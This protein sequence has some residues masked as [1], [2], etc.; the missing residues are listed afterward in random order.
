MAYIEVVAGLVFLVFAGDYLVRGAVSLARRAGIS[1]MIIALT[2][3]AFGTSAPELMVGVDAV[4]KG[5]PTL[6]LGNIVGSNIANVLLVVGLPAIIAPMTC[7]APRIKKNLIIM[8][9]A[10]ALFIGMAFSGTFTAIH[11][12]ALL[13]TLAIFIG[14]SIARRKNCP[15]EAAAETADMEELQHKPD[16]YS[17]ATLMV[18][19]GLI[20]LII[21]A[22]LLVE[23]ATAIAHDFGVS[24]AVIGLTLVALGTSLP[25]LM[26]AMM[27]A[28]R[29]HCE[30][31]VGNVIGSNIFNLLCIGGAASTVGDIPVPASFLQVDLWVMLGASLLLIPFARSGARMG[32]T[33]GI[34]MVVMYVGYI[35]YLAQSGESASA[36]GMTL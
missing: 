22:D 2:I 30:V 6:A 9:G 29:G 33:A 23:G 1:K 12:I 24:D 5:A 15:M 26:T 35:F 28:I 18:V 17:I 8:L 16:R 4:L 13:G 10:T 19:G 27:A 14:Y 25:E 36:M 32:K 11:G 3:V 21:G 20:G 7:T 31:A 34:A